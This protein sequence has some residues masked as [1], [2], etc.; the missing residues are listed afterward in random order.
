MKGFLKVVLGAAL[1]TLLAFW[2]LVFIVVG[3]VGGMASALWKGQS[4]VPKEGTV[5]RIA[6]SGTLTDDDPAY[7]WESLLSEEESNS[8]KGLLEAIRKAG[9][10][11]KVQGI[12][13]EAKGLSTGTADR[14][15]LRRALQKFKE[16][17]KFVVAYGDIYSQGDYFVC[18]VADRLFLNPQGMVELSGLSMH[19]LF[20]KGISEKL[21]IEWET[22]KVGAYKGAVESYTL[23]RL[24]A[25][26]REQLESYTASVWNVITAGIAESRGISPAQIDSLAEAG[27]MMSPQEE[28]VSGGLVDA[29]AYRDEAEAYVKELAGQKS[30][31]LETVEVT[32]L[33]NLAE[34][35]KTASDNEI[36]FLYDVP[37]PIPSIGNSDNEIAILYAEGTITEERFSPF[38]GEEPTI[39]ESVADDL[40]DL[41]ED[42]AV[43]AV[44]FRINSPGGSSYVSEQIWHQ[45]SQL[46]KVKPVIV[47]MGSVAASGGYYIACAAQRIYAEPATLTGSIG[48]Y[49][50]IPVLA[51]TLEKAG[52]TGDGVKTH[53]YADFG[54]ITR[55]FRDDER[56]LLQAYVERGYR[57]FLS[58]CAEGRT[59]SLEAVDS[60]AQGRIWTGEQAL[61]NGLVDALGGIDDAIA[62][63]A[64]A[65][66]LTD[67]RVVDVS[68]STDFWQV[69]IER[70]VGSLRS[71]IVKDFAGADYAFLRSLRTLRTP[72]PLQARLPLTIQAL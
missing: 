1:G 2:L 37:L 27:V 58:R 61:A 59:M 57:L 60:I 63:A 10:H 65:A 16:K 52:I 53:R 7:S 67:Y 66:D 18:S 34:H 45:V 69:S 43:K 28:T 46:S 38:A 31:W 15:A 29:L 54:D 68:S 35:K 55:P 22:F 30:T 17:G 56:G 8:L 32:D 12:Y 21:G 23:D 26:N 70:I 72:T 3:A 44:V 41:R 25:A 40:A 48:I 24:S 9:E 5:L 71:A 47:S 36:A 51:G 6:L 13:L 42:E 33:R 20:Y 11:P 4:F 14:Q 50:Q 62:A 19:T 64:S 39:T 49:A